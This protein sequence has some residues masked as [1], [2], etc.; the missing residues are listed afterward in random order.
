MSERTRLGRSTRR[1]GL[2]AMF[3]AVWVLALMPVALAHT[4]ASGVYCD[5][6]GVYGINIRGMFNGH[7]GNFF[8][9]YSEVDV[10]DNYGSDIICGHI[11]NPNYTA[12]PKAQWQTFRNFNLCS[13]S[14]II[15]ATSYTS[16]MAIGTNYNWSTYCGGAGNWQDQGCGGLSAGA[17]MWCHPMS[18]TSTH[19]F[20]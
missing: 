13:S 2:M 11:G 6:N 8:G 14:V 10:F 9:A 17:T 19:S 7:S 5:D 3:V 12:L 1:C 15:Q 4:L 20:P 16:K 18:R